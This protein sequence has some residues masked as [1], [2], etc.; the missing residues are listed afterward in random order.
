MVDSELRAILTPRKLPLYDM[1]VYHFGWDET[2]VPSCPPH[3]RKLGVL[4]LTSTMANKSVP[5]V[6]IP[7][8]AAMEFVDKFCEIHE[9]VQGGKPKRGHR[10]AVWWVWGPAQAI[11]T[12]DGMH[13]MARLSLF[14]LLERGI[15]HRKAFDVVQLLDKASLRACEGRFLDIQAQERVDV[16]SKAYLEMAS[17]K[18]GSLYG[19]AASIGARIAD[20]DPQ[21][22]SSLNRFGLHIG[23][24]SLINA[25][26]N[27]LNDVVAASSS[28]NDDLMNKKKSLPVVMAFEN[29]TATGRRQLGDYYFKRVLEP[30]D[31]PPLRALVKE[32]GGLD[33][34]KNVLGNE[35][36]AALEALDDAKL[37]CAGRKLLTDYISLIM[38]STVAT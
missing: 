30:N 4:T 24:A 31:L 1:M 14:S 34:A 18:E 28:P 13:A 36:S 26:L 22:I 7:A 35:I 3:H 23:T 37:D 21:R 25:E 5:D 32:L 27:Q 38:E 19:C 10:D 29:A 2:S 15:D 20:A 6:A 33:A 16:T 12:G 11:N 8:A 17:A 9:D